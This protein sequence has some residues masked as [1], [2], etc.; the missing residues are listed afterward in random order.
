M[1]VTRFILG[2]LGGVFV[3]IFGSKKIMIAS[4]LLRSLVIAIIFFFFVFFTVPI[5]LLYFLAIVFGAVERF[6]WPAAEA[7]KP[8]LLEKNTFLKPIAVTSLW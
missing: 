7:I 3:D 8:K 1:G 2:L 6:Y 5:G 4:D